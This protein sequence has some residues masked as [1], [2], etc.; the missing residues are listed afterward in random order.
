MINV[1][2][3]TISKNESHVFLKALLRMNKVFFSLIHITLKDYG[4][5]KIL[6]LGLSVSKII[7][8]TL[9]LCVYIYLTFVI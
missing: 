7:K 2:K 6:C 3:S 5:V 8:Q 9:F 4:T 1:L